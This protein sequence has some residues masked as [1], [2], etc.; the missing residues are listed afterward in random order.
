MRQG[1]EEYSG[2]KGI[3]IIAGMAAVFIFVVWGGSTLW[4]MLLF[5]LDDILTMAHRVLHLII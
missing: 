2:M 5:V 1:S 3:L 4:A